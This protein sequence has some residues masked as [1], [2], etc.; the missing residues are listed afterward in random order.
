MLQSLPQQIFIYGS[1]IIDNT[2]WEHL[3]ENHRVQTFQTDN[4]Y[5]LQQYSLE[6]TPQIL[7]FN[8]SDAASLVALKQTLT[9][10]KTTP[11]IILLSPPIEI[12]HLPPVAHHLHHPVNLAE[13]TEIIESYSLG[14]HQ[15]D[16]LLL[17]SPNKNFN[18][19]K[20]KLLQAGYSVFETHTV[21]AAQLYLQ[22]NTAHAVLIEYMPQ[23]IA[24][25][26][27]LQHERIFYV[28]RQQDITEISK[29]LH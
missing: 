20:Q 10:L 19:L 15:H 9:R 11:L 24:G 8:I 29:F 21:A 14:H 25:R 3:T 4:I 6:I 13:L 22:K 1:P 23:F 18:P 28:D 5:Q 16:A 26:H 2:V 7:I 27:Y 17:D 12:S